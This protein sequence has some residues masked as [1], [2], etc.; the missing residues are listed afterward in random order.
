MAGT[1]KCEFAQILQVP[2]TVDIAK[3]ARLPVVT[4]LY[5]VLGYAG[6]INSGL[7]GHVSLA[8]CADEAE[9]LGQ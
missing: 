7:S 4:A 8:V 3:E 5:D 2:N 6:K 9:V 1:C